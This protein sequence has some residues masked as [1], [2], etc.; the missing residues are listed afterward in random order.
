MSESPYPPSLSASVQNT[1]AGQQEPLSEAVTVAPSLADDTEYQN[2]CE[3]DSEDIPS[4]APMGM[5]AS[6]GSSPTAVPT[7]P[8]IALTFLLV[9][10]RRR[11]MTFD[12]DAT[13]GRVK[14]LIWN[15]WPAD[16]QDERPPAPSYLRVLHLGKIWQDDDMLSSFQLAMVPAA[17]TIV[18]LAIRQHPVPSDDDLKKK[19]KRQPS[20]RS[21]PGTNTEEAVSGGCCGCIIC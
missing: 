20:S 14:E 4:S 21:V 8:Q 6:M 11:S 16:W 5:S 15:A 7:V 12:P 3:D 18:H 1:F 17:P 2:R 9:S 13:V 10:G 19:R